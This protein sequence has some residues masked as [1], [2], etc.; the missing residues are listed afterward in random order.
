M[1]PGPGWWTTMETGAW[2]GRAATPAFLPRGRG[3]GRILQH[4]GPPVMSDFLLKLTLGAAEEALEQATRL[5]P[6]PKAETRRFAGHLVKG[7]AQGEHPMETVSR[8]FNPGFDMMAK[9]YERYGRLFPP[10]SGKG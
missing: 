4:R 2:N 8:E 5:E 3:G 10:T 1:Q 9:G 7:R 6:K